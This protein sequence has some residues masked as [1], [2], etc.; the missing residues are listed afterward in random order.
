LLALPFSLC[1]QVPTSMNYQGIALDATDNVIVD[2]T[3]GIQT[4]LS[5]GGNIIYSENHVTETDQTGAFQVIIGE[6]EV[7][8]GD[9]ESIDWSAGNV[10][11]S[12]N[13]DPAGGTL[14]SSN[15]FTQLWSVPYAFLAYDVD[16]ANP[17]PMGPAGL[18]GPIN[19][20]GPTG[21]TGPQGPAGPTGPAGPISP[22]G[23]VGPPGPTGPMGT[24]YGPTGAPGAPGIPGAHGAPGAQGPTGPPGPP[25]PPLPPPPPG[26]TGPVGSSLWNPT[27]VGMHLATPGA[28]IVLSDSN[29]NCWVLSVA[30]DGSILFNTSNCE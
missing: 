1:A 12:V 23:L 11:L 19:P 5:S 16:F 20:Q 15:G 21:I 22:P 7:T 28:G 24:P 29:G 13:I 14:F 17:G 25:S 26:P 27:P 8:L 30:N 2:S 3:V 6:G 10:M 4:A 18:P 9:Y